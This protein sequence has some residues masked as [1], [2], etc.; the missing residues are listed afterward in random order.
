MTIEVPVAGG[1]VTAVPALRYRAVF[2]LAVRRAFDH[3]AARPGAVAVELGPSA[4]VHLTAWVREL[5]TEQP[6]GQSLPCMLGLVRLNRRIHPR[7]K[8][9]SLRLQEVH[10]APL[11]RL[12]PWLLR[13]DLH[14]AGLSLL[15]LSATDS[16]VEAVRCAVEYGMAVHGVDL[17]D[18]ASCPRSEAFC[19]DPVGG[20]DD[21]AAYVERNAAGCAAAR[22]PYVDGRRERIMAARLKELV[23]Q[24]GKVL[25]T[26][27]LAHWTELRRL[28]QDRS[29]PASPMPAPDE[30]LY[31]RVLV[32]P[33]IAVHQMDVLPDYTPYYEHVRPLQSVDMSNR[34]RLDEDVPLKLLSAY[35]HAVAYADGY[36]AEIAKDRRQSFQVYLDNLCLLR[37]LM[38]PDLSCFLAAAAAV[39]SEDFAELLGREL[40]TAP[41]IQW[42][43]PANMPELPYLRALPWDAHERHLIV[44]C[45][46][47]ELVRPDG[48]QGPCFV[49]GMLPTGGQSI[50]AVGS[51][52]VEPKPEGPRPGADGDG[53]FR[54]GI[55][56]WIWPP[57]ELLFFGTA[58][59][60]A[61]QIHT[62][63][64]HEDVPFI[65]SLHEGIAMKATVRSAVRNDNRI[66]VR[67]AARGRPAS[68][69]DAMAGPFVYIFE[70]PPRERSMSAFT[71]E[72]LLAGVMREQYFR[73]AASRR[74]FQEIV[75]RQGNAFVS[76]VHFCE[77]RGLSGDLARCRAIDKVNLLWGS[78]AFG[79]PCINIFQCARWL[80]DESF[81]CCPALR[82]GSMDALVEQYKR[83]YGVSLDLYDWTETLVRI[84]IQKARRRVLVIAPD[85]SAIT[86]QARIE[87]RRRR[88]GI[89]VVPLS[90]VSAERLAAVRN[91]YCVYPLDEGAT[92]WSREVTDLLG[93]SDAHIDL[94]P[95]WIR[96]QM[97]DNG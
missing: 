97:V 8:A 5:C 28:L 80:E 38:V 68:L 13:Q 9:A 88:V 23:R 29:L 41:Q 39:V 17:E 65:G 37:Q 4:A 60:I 56:R 1:Q 32:D 33:A 24:Y 7:F 15:C 42:L 27:S 26:G 91:Q 10:A 16:I 59:Q 71:W 93:P 45:H 35:R 11:H 77:A 19:E 62:S 20:L 54:P 3:A 76:C 94:L 12:P 73:L 84:A 83:D 52:F 21:L 31:E 69:R 61:E 2:A 57:C 96:A 30:S 51:Y 72:L 82:Y 18:F 22:D 36:T 78:V 48:R 92:Q 44:D 55:R 14:Y 53:H 81:N 6:S 90:Y 89:D 86:R 70:T 50:F 67:E 58:F 66:Y 64:G 43:Q 79:N 47:A 49:E 63:T 34:F 95:P 75:E 46:K 25:F 85:R 74:K 40:M 87:A